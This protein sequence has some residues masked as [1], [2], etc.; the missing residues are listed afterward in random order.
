MIRRL[1]D[2]ILFRIFFLCRFSS[3][4]LCCHIWNLMIYAFEKNFWT[5]QGVGFFALVLGYFNYRNFIKSLFFNTFFYDGR[6]N[7]FGDVVWKW[8]FREE[9][10][11]LLNDSS[12]NFNYVSLCQPKAPLNSQEIATNSF[13]TV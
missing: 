2:W 5:W 6:N 11:L 1:H 12:S 8:R 10:F 9:F 3:S 7:I 4:F 13:K